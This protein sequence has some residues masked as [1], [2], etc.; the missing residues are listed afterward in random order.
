MSLLQ[1]TQ[2]LLKILAKRKPV[3]SRVSFLLTF[4]R[5]F[6]EFHMEV[7][8]LWMFSTIC[9]STRKRQSHLEGW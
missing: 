9:G 2:G 8:S 4:M 6:R 7:W 3:E 1:K 5:M